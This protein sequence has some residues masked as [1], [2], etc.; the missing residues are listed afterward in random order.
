M[1]LN[2]TA[3][4]TL[5][6]LLETYGL[7]EASEHDEGDYDVD[8]GE[9]PD[10]I[11]LNVRCEDLLAAALIGRNGVNL[12]ALQ[13]I[14]F[15]ALAYRIGGTIERSVW[16]SVNGR[17]PVLKPAAEQGEADTA[18]TPTTVQGAPSAPQGT[19]GGPAKAAAGT[20]LS[21]IVSVPENVEVIVRTDRR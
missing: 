19:P 1:S 5:S 17:R 14:F 12:A 21:I 3:R 10:T 13:R 11:S 16:I 4:S 18:P 9:T 2:E 20:R 8:E 15:S 6:Q 7:V